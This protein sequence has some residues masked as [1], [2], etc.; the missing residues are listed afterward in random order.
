MCV[1]EREGGNR[2]RKEHEDSENFARFCRH[3][4][5]FIFICFS[6][7]STDRLYFTLTFWRTREDGHTRSMVT[8]VKEREGMGVDHPPVHVCPGKK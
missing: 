1:R 2:E 5:F 8:Q 6:E 4:L 3:T 7:P